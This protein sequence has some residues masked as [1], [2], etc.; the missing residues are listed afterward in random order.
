L[1]VVIVVATGYLLECDIPHDP[2]RRASVSN[3]HMMCRVCSAFRMRSVHLACKPENPVKITICEH[4]RSMRRRCARS[5]TASHFRQSGAIKAT[6]GTQGNVRANDRE[7]LT[8]TAAQPEHRQRRRC[9]RG[10][11]L[12]AAF[13]WG[14]SAI[15]A[16]RITGYASPHHGH[17]PNVRLG[18]IAAGFSLNVIGGFPGYALRVFPLAGGLEAESDCVRYRSAATPFS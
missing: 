6:G 18:R 10:Q 15:A 11:G 2:R 16:L 12:D 13:D 5:G 4:R 14:R 17:A 9:D 7:E 1:Q 3:E 8:G